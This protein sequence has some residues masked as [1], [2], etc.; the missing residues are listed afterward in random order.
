MERWRL[1]GGLIGVAMLA[2]GSTSAGQPLAQGLSALKLVADAPLTGA[3]TRFDYESLD[4][5]THLLFIAHLG[6]SMVTVVDTQER[7]VIADIPGIGHVHGV[8]AIP[9]LGRVYASATKTDEIVVIDEK[10][11]KIT[12]RI[13]G[14]VYP[15]GMAYVPGVHK[16]YVSD[17][18]GTTETVIDAAAN[19]RI[20]TLHLWSVVGNSQYDPVSKHVFVTAQTRDQLIEI[21]PV[22]DRIVA[23]HDLPGGKGPHGL[24]IDP[25]GRFAFVACEGNDTL[26]IFDMTT[27]QLAGSFD[28]GKDPDVLAFDPGMRLLYVAGEQGIVSLFSVQNRVVKKIG[29]G[30]LAANAHVVAVDAQTHRAYF[31]L[32]DVS[33]HPAL[34]I[35]EPAPISDH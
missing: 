3:T 2:C 24:L 23:R 6:D 29:E 14:G 20:A 26:L 9:E 33:G 18:A 15:D 21:D 22:S 28:V 31:P 17:E 5:Q 10:T 7:R 25:E 19:R 4:P 32:S 1:A 8:L 12:A 30:F 16:L 13:P 34:R 35:M 11:L 27:M